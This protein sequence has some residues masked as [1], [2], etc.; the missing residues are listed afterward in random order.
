MNLTEVANFINNQPEDSKVYIG[1]DSERIIKDNIWYADYT[2]VVV[3]H[4]AGR[5]GCKIFGETIRE[6][7]FDAKISR[8]SLRLMNEVYKVSELYLKLNELVYTEIEI[9]LDINPSKEH[10][11]SLV[12]QQA[13]GYIKG[14]CMVE[15]KVKPMAF[16]ASAA[17]DRYK[18]LLAA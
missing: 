2:T 3:I 18:S 8:P 6:R 4:H 11:S 12:V 5:K 7:D 17:A 1:C 10:N 16:A 14:V 9:H 15:P 13:V